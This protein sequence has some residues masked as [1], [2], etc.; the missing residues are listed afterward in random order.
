[1]TKMRQWTLLAA[2]AALAI[3]AGGWFL[4]VSPQRSK[5]SD[6]RSQVDAQL[7]TNQGLQSQ[8][9]ALQAQHKDVPKVQAQLSKLAVQ[10]PDNPGLPG[11][12]RQ[13]SAAADDAGVDLVSLAPA[14]PQLQTTSTA[15]VAASGAAAAAAPATS[16]SSAAA[17]ART[18]GS[19][20]G[21]LAAIP[22][23]INVNGGYFQI[24]QF[25]SNLEA[26]KRSLL[27]SQASLVPGTPTGPSGASSVTSSDGYSGY[28]TGTLTGEVFMVAPPAPAVVRAPTTTSTD[29]S[30]DS[31]ATTTP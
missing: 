31:S 27:V 13:L 28:L 7:S 12:I 16:A 1:M 9:T 20:V 29:T 15:A 25:L 11:L 19:S 2:V 26:L 6:L 5:A 18:T 30:A 22:V 8:L 24:E 21:R 10:M 3:L 17:T 14:A 23:T 4:M